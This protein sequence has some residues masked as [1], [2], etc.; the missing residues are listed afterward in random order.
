MKSRAV[1]FPDDV[2]SDRFLPAQLSSFVIKVLSTKG[3]PPSL[4]IDMSG[5]DIMQ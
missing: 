1:S 5:L 4:L 2:V 3:A